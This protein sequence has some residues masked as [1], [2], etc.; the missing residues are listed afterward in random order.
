MKKFKALS[1][2][3]AALISVGM[4]AGCGDSNTSSS[5]SAGAADQSS[6]SDTDVK[7]KY[8]GE[9]IIIY[10]RMMDSQD[11]WFRENT[12]ANFQKE[13]GVNVTVKTFESEADMMN[14]LKLDAD[15]G[16]IGVVKTLLSSVPAFEAGDYIMSINDVPNADMDAIKDKFDNNALD[17]VTIDDNIY[18]LPRK[19]ENY[20]LVY[21]KDKVEDAVANWETQ[22]PVIEAAFKSENGVGLP[23][24]YT[25]EADPNEWDWYDLGVVGMYW[26]NT[27]IDGKVEPRIAHRTKVYEGTTIEIM[28]RVFAMNG[29]PDDMLD[30]TSAPVVE[31]MKWE[32]FFVNNNVYNATMWDEMWSGGGIW[33]AFASGDVYMAYMSQMDEFFIHGGSSPDMQGY[34][35]DP[36]NMG[37]AL[38]PAGASFELDSNGQ[39]AVKGVSAAFN[40]GWYWSIPK[41]APNPELSLELINYITNVDNMTAESTTFG[42][43]PVTNE[44]LNNLDTLISES[45]MQD[46]FNVGKEQASGIL[47]GVPNQSKWPEIS[48]L[49][50]QGW[51]DVALVDDESKVEPALEELKSKIEP[52]LDK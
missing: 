41:T 31:T 40:N 50:Q 43:L 46:V 26:G 2:A 5:G 19:G 12:I 48:S 49:W 13:Y 52:L 39:P 35:A 4:L 10:I 23:A 37:V 25:L 15:K 44:V 1:L 17:A 36:D 47:Y 32:N 7:D 3:L 21:A 8:K 20:T 45:W 30:P 29:T 22:K 16:K 18:A 34:M 28:S 33:N 27:E 24:D 11:K 6:A 51:H 9:D 42:I 14:V 38:L